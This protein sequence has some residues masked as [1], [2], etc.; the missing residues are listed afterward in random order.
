M[1][2]ARQI[3]LNEYKC[4]H[5]HLVFGSQC[6]HSISLGQC[7]QA[8]L[9]TP[10][11][12]HHQMTLILKSLRIHGHLEDCCLGSKDLPKVETSSG[13][14]FAFFFCNLSV[15]IIPLYVFD[16]ILFGDRTWVAPMFIDAFAQTARLLSLS[17][18]KKSFTVFCK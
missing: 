16:I 13:H 4:A 10:K 5:W 18:R 9:H 12:F 8:H 1:F 3:K 11:S 15:S 7:L 17:I 14:F 2:G 6:S